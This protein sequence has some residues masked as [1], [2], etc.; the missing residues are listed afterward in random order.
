MESTIT[1]FDKPGPAN[2]EATLNL[3]RERANA[4]GIQQIIV[5]SSTGDTAIKAIDVFQGMRVIVVGLSTGPRFLDREKKEQKISQ[6]FSPKAKQL[7]EAKGGVVLISTTVFGGMNRAFR[8]Q[9][10]WKATPLSL[11]SAALRV[12]GT[13]M[14]VACEIT[15][16]A[17]DAGLINTEEDAVAIAGVV[18]GADTAIVLRPVNAA[19]FFNLK[20][21]E[22][23]CKPRLG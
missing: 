1:Y 17:A 16:M 6:P 19:L 15:M 23:I 9:L 18:H 8:D 12:F 2:T 14:K 22:I 7:V 20:I 3:A 4:L 10:G 11:I 13:G 21:K 5:A